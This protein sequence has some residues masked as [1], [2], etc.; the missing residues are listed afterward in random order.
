MFAHSSKGLFVVNIIDRGLVPHPN[1]FKEFICITYCI[2][3][4]PF[5]TA[6]AY[7]IV[8]VIRNRLKA[9]SIHLNWKSIGDI[10]PTHIRATILTKDRSGKIISVRK[11]RKAE[12]SHKEIYTALGMDVK[13]LQKA[14][15]WVAGLG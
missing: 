15:V 6:T 7:H 5:I 9:S 14:K 13:L 8:Q 10:L 11:D 12:Y 1:Y 2:F 4:N 3:N